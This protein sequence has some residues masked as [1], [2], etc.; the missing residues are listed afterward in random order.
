MIFLI[1]ILGTGLMLSGADKNPVNVDKKGIAIKGYDPVAYF[2]EGEP[3]KGSAEFQHE[4]N[5]A[6]WHFSSAEHRDMFKAEPEKYAPQYGGYCA[7][8]VSQGKT[9]NIDPDAWK[10]VDG[11][12]YLNLNK[13]IHRK[14]EKDI[15]GY[16]KKADKNWPGVLKE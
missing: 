9:A 15:L 2:T 12:L 11:K 4:W 10:I 16:I 8:A 3:V 7:Y 6:I 13:R 1:L 14:W 5:S